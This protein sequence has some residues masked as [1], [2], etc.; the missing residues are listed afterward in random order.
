M[1]ESYESIIEKQSKTTTIIRTVILILFLFFTIFPLLWIFLTSLKGR[2]DI[3]AIPPRFIFTPT[4]ENYRGLF[5]KT[6]LEGGVGQTDFGLVLFNSVIEAGLGTFFA[7]VLGV[8]AGYACSRFNFFGKNDYLFFTLSTRMLPAV[9]VI[10]PIYIMFSRLGL[11]DTRIGMILIYTMTN[12]GLAI[13]IMKGFFDSL[14]IQD[15][16]AGFVDGYTRWQIFWKIL[17]PSVKGGI[18]ATL[19]FC[20]IFAWNEFTFATILTT[21]FAKTLPPRITTALGAAG[22]EW[23]QVAAAG[24]IVVIPVLILFILIRNYL[25]MGMTF[26]VLG[27]R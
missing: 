12:L 2:L 6:F 18:A 13:W 27:R 22:L 14:P 25:L 11:S 1:V 19:G 21:R 4:F 17:I 10:I 16:E 24:F 23:G 26:G 20:F 7:V 5:V 15:E 3:F 8:M 9:A